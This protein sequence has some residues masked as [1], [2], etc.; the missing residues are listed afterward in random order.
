MEKKNFGSSFFRIYG[1]HMRRI[2]KY[3][4]YCEVE[5]YELGECPKL[6][7]M[8]S[9]YNKLYYRR[10]AVAMDYDEE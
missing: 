3:A 10:E 4:T 5:D 9:K 7:G 2:I 6:E 1:G 8:L